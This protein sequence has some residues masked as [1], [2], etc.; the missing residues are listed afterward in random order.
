MFRSF[1]THLFKI[2]TRLKE[3][4]ANFFNNYLMTFFKR[5]KLVSSFSAYEYYKLSTAILF[6]FINPKL[7]IIQISSQIESNN[8]HKII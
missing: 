1:L 6:V 4:R 5:Q 8:L 3:S 7:F 2:F